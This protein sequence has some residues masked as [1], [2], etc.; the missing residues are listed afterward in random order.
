MRERIILKVADLPLH[1]RHS[2]SPTWWGTL[3]FM[4]LEGSAFAVCIAIYIYL[5]TVAPAWPLAAPPPGLGAGTLVTVILL[6]SLIPNGLLARW[7]SQQNLRKVQVGTV[8]M[9]MFGIAPLVVRVFEFRALNIWWDANAYGSVLWLLLGLHSTHLVTDV[10]DTMV[11]LVLMFTRHGDNRRRFGDVEDNVMYWNFV[12]IT[13]LPIYL[14]I[15][16]IPRL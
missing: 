10:I 5:L 8:I 13:W 11:L 7:A 12:V 6:A 15:Y 2:A 16:W 14:C 1:G 9:T 3:A 4:L